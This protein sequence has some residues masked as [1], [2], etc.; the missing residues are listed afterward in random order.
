MSKITKLLLVV[1]STIAYILIVTY[2]LGRSFV[3]IDSWNDDVNIVVTD[4]DNDTFED[5]NVGGIST[6]TTKDIVC[7][8]G[9][10]PLNDKKVITPYDLPPSSSTI[11]PILHVLVEQRCVTPSTYDKINQHWKP[12]QYSLVF[13]DRHEL[14][15]LLRKK[16]AMFPNLQNV[17][18]CITSI[19]HEIDLM[20][21]LVMWEY[22]GIVADLKFLFTTG[23]NFHVLQHFL[24]Y[25]DEAFLVIDGT[26][27]VS[28]DT[29]KESS[30]LTTM[31]KDIM[32]P[33]R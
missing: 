2:I 29:A 31:V 4:D 22:G 21:L 6:T 27:S 3:C 14:D 26:T 32:D 12:K 13:H 28:S 15:K 17:V 23:N 18:R 20:K 8:P 10:V 16:R 30:L 33:S 24:D 25:N 1:A 7:P 11:P 19:H 5:G 9:Q